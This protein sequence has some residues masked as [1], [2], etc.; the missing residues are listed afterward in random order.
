M[1]LSRTHCK[2]VR[3]CISFV[4]TSGLIKVKGT[5]YKVLGFFE[6]AS[7]AIMKLINHNMFPLMSTT[8]TVYFHTQKLRV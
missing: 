7:F 6:C 1:Y 4:K 2:L 3:E 5:V 8:D